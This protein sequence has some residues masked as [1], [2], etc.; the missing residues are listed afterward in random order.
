[1]IVDQCT[2]HQ[3]VSRMVCK[4]GESNFMRIT[5]AKRKKK[6]FVQLAHNKDTQQII[7]LQ[8]LLEISSSSDNY[9]YRFRSHRSHRLCERFLAV[10]FSKQNSNIFS[11]WFMQNFK[12]RLQ[13]IERKYNTIQFSPFWE[14]AARESVN[15]STRGE[16]E[17]MWHATGKCAK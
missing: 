15:R 17:I 13:P 2:H 16:E 1:M 3:N 8:L 11:D 6:K 5:W 10:R 4:W 12:I 9:L 14:F 7:L